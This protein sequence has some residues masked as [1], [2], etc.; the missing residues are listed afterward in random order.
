MSP[1]ATKDLFRKTWGLFPT[2][3]TIVTFYTGAG[4]IHGLTA[5]SVCSVSLEPFLVLVCVDHK[6][7]SFPMLSKQDRFVMNFLAQGQ[8]EACTFFA[9]SDTE[10]SGPYTFTKSARG[11]PVLDGCVAYMECSIQAKHR[12]GDHT[13]F[14]GE[15]KE[16]ELLGGEPLVFYQGKFTKVVPPAA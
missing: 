1:A 9:R 12:A 2:G 5:N 16:I 7:R 15:V 8:R 13:I 4:A 6:A 11:Y 10:G 3:V 14:V